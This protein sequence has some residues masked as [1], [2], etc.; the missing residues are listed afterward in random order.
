MESAHEHDFHAFSE[1]ADARSGTRSPVGLGSRSSG[2]QAQ[3][4]R[5]PPAAST[6]AALSAVGDLH[7]DRRLSSLAP[8]NQHPN[9]VSSNN[10]S[11]DPRFRSGG[12]STINAIQNMQNM[13]AMIQQ[14]QQQQ[15]Q[16]AAMAQGQD[17]NMSRQRQQMPIGSPPM[18][19][20]NSPQMSPDWN[21]QPSTLQQ[22]QMIQQQVMQ[23]QQHFPPQFIQTPPHNAMQPQAHLSNTDGQFHIPTSYQSSASTPSSTSSHATFHSS[24]PYHTQ[25][26]FKHDHDDAIEMMQVPLH[27]QP[28]TPRG[29]R[30]L[31]HSKHVLTIPRCAATTPLLS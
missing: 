19:S 6:G 5:C 18:H 23:Q 4:I 22:Q 17:F 21:V 27:Q 26:S 3:V 29:L 14:Q 25:S 31:T 12:G 1:N 13:Q 11:N 2:E 20:D 15:Q 7:G 30:Q 9:H 28:Q 24:S 16:H 8:E 10:F